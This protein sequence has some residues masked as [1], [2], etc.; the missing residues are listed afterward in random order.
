MRDGVRHRDTDVQTEGRL[1]SRTN[2][3]YKENIR[4][5]NG[6]GWNTHS[7]DTGEE[8]NAAH[9]GHEKERG[10]GCTLSDSITIRLNH[11]QTQSLS[12]SIS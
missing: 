3:I 2:S 7:R 12:D 10:K 11:Y 9:C 4:P 5:H 1:L 6:E 8:L